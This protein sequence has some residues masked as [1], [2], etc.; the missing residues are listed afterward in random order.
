MSRPTSQQDIELL[1]GCLLK[2]ANSS[3]TES[4][5]R[6]LLADLL[7]QQNISIIMCVPGIFWFSLD[8]LEHSFDGH[9]LRGLLTAWHNYIYTDCER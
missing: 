8:F 1:T 7:M 9:S 6:C 5:K 4:K 2:K 3:P